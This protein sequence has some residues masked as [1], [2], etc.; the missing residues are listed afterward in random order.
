[1]SP[2]PVSLAA[3]ETVFAAARA[4]KEHGVGT[5]L[6][7]TDGRFTGLLTDRDI[8][9]RVLAENRD[10]R[11]TRIGDIC[12]TSLTVLGPDDDVPRPPGWSAS[13]RCAAFRS[14]GRDP[15]RRR[16]QRR[17][18]AGPG[19]GAALSDVSSAPPNA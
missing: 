17:P 12:S 8:T 11:S 6:V 9:I 2:A 10:P 4:M 19:R 14:S 1:M 3:T 18:R 7:S 15:G 5:V 16:V 13:A